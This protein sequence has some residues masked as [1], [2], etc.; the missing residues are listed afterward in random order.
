MTFSPRLLKVGETMITRV[1]RNYGDATSG[2]FVIVGS[3]G[4]LEISVK[5]ASAAEVLHLR[6]GQ[7]VEVMGS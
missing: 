3:T 5:N 7:R 1:E 6:R 4:L 2:P